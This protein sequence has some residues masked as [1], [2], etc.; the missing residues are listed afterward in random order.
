MRSA[1]WESP[2]DP[3]ADP[4][5]DTVAEPVPVQVA[6]PETV[7]ITAC[8]VA[9]LRQLPS[10]RVLVKSFADHHPGATCH[11]LL[12]DCDRDTLAELGALGRLAEGARFVLPADLG[13]AD[14]ELARLRTA[15]A[16]EDLC[17]VLRPRLMH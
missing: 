6:E 3:A 17:A 13:I 4:V 10:V 15:F 1:V 11:A 9:S 16:P 7:A 12:V 8:T 2:A 5:A 14:D